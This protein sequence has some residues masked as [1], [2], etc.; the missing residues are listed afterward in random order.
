MNRR[1]PVA[2]GR[3]DPDS[4]R[5]ETKAQRLD[6]NLTELVSELRVALPGVQVL[7]AFLLVVPFNQRFTQTTQFERIVYF[8]TLLLT[9]ATCVLL[10]AP[11]VHHR[12]QF[13]QQEKEEIVL[14]GNR[15][16]V[17]GLAM[18]ALAVT[19]AVLFVTDFLI[20]GVAAVVTALALVLL[21]AVVW[22][23]LPLRGRSGSGERAVRRS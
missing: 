17:V 8:V 7:L 15:V 11:S 16:A 19:G 4:P 5:A 20:G 9:A 2:E 1:H 14:L 3:H 21:F 12:V 13:R 22:Y 6:R 10:I 23:V 18:L